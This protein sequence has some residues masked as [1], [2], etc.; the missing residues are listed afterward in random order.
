V[1]SPALAR[2]PVQSMTVAS[3]EIEAKQPAPA[4]EPAIG[5]IAA[6]WYRLN[7]DKLQATLIGA[8]SLVAFLIALAP[9]DEIPRGVLCPLHQR[10]LTAGGL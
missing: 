7:K 9:A 1:S 8:I 3:Q 5:A 2:D 4:P 10:A 6:R